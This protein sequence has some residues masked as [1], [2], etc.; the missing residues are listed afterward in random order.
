MD[1]SDYGSDIDI[2]GEDGILRLLTT[3]TTATTTATP[4]TTTH[5]GNPPVRRGGGADGDT[6]SPSAVSPTS[7]LASQCSQYF[8][9]LETRTPPLPPPLC[10]AAQ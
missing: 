10:A 2:D 7:S 6:A 3:P 9:C 8:D 4:A 1:S 5:D